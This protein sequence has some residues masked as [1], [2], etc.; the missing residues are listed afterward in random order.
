MDVFRPYILIFQNLYNNMGKNSAKKAAAKA[1][2]RAAFEA[3]KVSTGNA[4]KPISEHK[5]ATQTAAP[6][7]TI[8]AA[9]PK[10]MAAPKPISITPPPVKVVAPP[11][12]GDG[13]EGYVLDSDLKED[14][15]VKFTKV[16]TL[17]NGE[18]DVIL[19]AK[20]AL[21][22]APG[23]KITFAFGEYSGRPT[24]L[25]PTIVEEETPLTDLFK[26]MNSEPIVKVGTGE[27][28]KQFFSVNHEGA[29]PT[30]RINN[31]LTKIGIKK[32]YG[33]ISHGVWG[34]KK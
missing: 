34:V 30:E 24:V 33:S 14:G 1:A 25:S 3:S 19:C 8:V 31:F 5:P 13:P 18:W 17:I 7:V 28:A 22:M 27:L 16:L 29:N 23:T 32:V 11:K 9:P 2:K 21:L 15:T 10:V 4:Q 12:V 6:P 20:P 26:Y